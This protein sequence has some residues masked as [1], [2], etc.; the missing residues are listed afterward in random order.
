MPSFSSVVLGL[1]QN[2]GEESSAVRILGGILADRAVHVKDEEA[3]A[4]AAR[5]RVV[6]H[7]FGLLEALMWNMQDTLEDRSVIAI[8]SRLR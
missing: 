7:A 8:A 3:D 2:E 1:S 4:A 5:Q 6:E